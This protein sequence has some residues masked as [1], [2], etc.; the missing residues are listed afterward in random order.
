MNRAI[1]QISGSRKKKKNPK[2]FKIESMAPP[3]NRRAS[4]A[5]NAALLADAR[6]LSALAHPRPDPPAARR[7][8]EWDALLRSHAAQ[9]WGRIAAGHGNDE[10]CVHTRC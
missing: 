4:G 3:L 9:E 2:N 5:R 6:A 7:V 1:E 8:R 10:T